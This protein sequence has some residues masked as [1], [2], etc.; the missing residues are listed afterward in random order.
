MRAPLGPDAG[1]RTMDERALLKSLGRMSHLSPLVGQSKT[2][3][4]TSLR[5]HSAASGKRDPSSVRVLSPVSRGVGR[6]SAN[7]QKWSRVPLPPVVWLPSRSS[8]APG[9]YD[10]LSL[11]PRS[12]A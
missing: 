2:K 11:V 4:F 12:Q 3:M 8:F 7:V 5:S 10:G 6:S 9:S 1:L